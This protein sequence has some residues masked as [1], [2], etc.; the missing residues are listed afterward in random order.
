MVLEKWFFKLGF[1]SGQPLLLNQKKVDLWYKTTLFSGQSL[2]SNQ[3]SQ[4]RF[5]EPL[6][7]TFLEKWL[8][9]KWSIFLNKIFIREE[10]E[11]VICYPHINMGDDKYVSKK[12]QRWPA[13]WS[14]ITKIKG[15]CIL[16]ISRVYCFIFL[17]SVSAELL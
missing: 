10:K 11:G 8:Q 4:T 12:M 17:L 1:F 5:L 15:G 14:G 7:Y 2:F 9:N 3:I 6:F 13:R 16:H